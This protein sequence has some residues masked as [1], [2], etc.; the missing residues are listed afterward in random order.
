MILSAKN[1]V[2]RVG[3]D[4]GLSEDD[5]EY[6][7]KIDK[8]HVFEIDLGN[9][10][11]HKAYRVQHNNLRG[12]YKGGIR[13]HPAV[14][15]DEVR[16]LSILMTLKTAAIGL[17]LGG[18]KGGVAI[19][20]RDLS[21]E[22][23]ERLS[24]AYVEHMHPHIGPDTDIPAPDVNTNA[25]I[26]DWMVEE[27]ENITGDN[28]KASF[29]GKSIENGGS[30]GREAATGRGGM[31]ALA[32]YLRLVGKDPKELTIAV[33][34]VGN[35]GFFFTK[36]A[37]EELGSRV[38]AISDSQRTL[39]VKDF[40][41]NKTFLSV[42][43]FDK[44]KRGLIDDLADEHV[45]FLDRDAILNQPVDVLVL[46]AL[47]DVVVKDNAFD[48]KASIILELANGPVDDFA[49]KALKDDKVIIPDIIANSGGVIVSYLEW[50][51]N[52]AGE[53]WSAQEVDEN[54]KIYM[55]KAVRS[56]YDYAKQKDI[57]LKE[58]ALALAITRLLESR[59]S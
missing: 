14:D 13:L 53:K 10:R 23:L 51:Q 22:D 54:L 5:I 49:F 45:E 34:G 46:A 16:A 19:D 15:L 37:Q 32:E 7:L 12:P 28:S 52:R 27:Y 2:T 35:V 38:V 11:T 40:Q 58:A 56:M 59:K 24:R 50:L 36:Y 29:T 39:L 25:K 18:G 21:E 44:S 26:I 17:P 6:L 4:L 57:P 55:S 30:L 1:L 8:E 20:P 48:I 33:Q 43:G 41:N 31:L 42:E 9:G 47:G 3:K